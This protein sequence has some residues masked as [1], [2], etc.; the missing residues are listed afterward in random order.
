MDPSSA[1]E[2]FLEAIAA[3]LSKALTDKETEKVIA[4]FNNFQQRLQRLSSQN[5]LRMN[6]EI[7]AREKRVSNC[8]HEGKTCTQNVT[9]GFFKTWVIGYIVKYLIGVLPA[10]LTGKILKNPGILKRSGGNDTVRFA[11]FLS[12]FLSAYKGVLCMMRHFRP[13]HKGDRLNAFVAGSVA[14][15]TLLLDKNKSRRTALTLY[16]FT[17]SI[18]FGSSYL[19]KKWAEHRDANRAADRQA[20]MNSSNRGHK[21]K[22]VSERRWDDI[23]AKIMTS[24]AATVVMSLTAA[25]NLYS[26]FLEPSAVRK[27][28]WNFIMEHSGLPQKFGPMF[29]PMVDTFRSQFN[30]LKEMPRGLEHISIPAGVPSRDFVAQ[31][32]S[33]NIATLIPSHLHHEFQL[34][35]LLHPL[36]PC[37][38]HAID[39][40]TGEFARAVKMY[41]TLNFIVTL[42]FQRKKL[43]TEPKEVAYRYIRSTLR[44]CMFLTVYVLAAFYVPCWMRAILRKET[45]FTYLFNGIVSGL[46][47]LIEAPG[48]QMELALYCLP[49]A[50]ETTWNLLLSRGLVRNI[51]HGDIA[52]F[53]A[54]MGVMMTI[55]QNDPSVINKHYLT[56]LTRIF[57]RN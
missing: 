10:I 50:L 52:L 5:L 18:Q 44:S 11:F 1:W 27:S 33:P 57:G 4:G 16:L 37:S 30:V 49:R 29:P 2:N 26:C 19:M 13:D 14:G 51:P 41:G 8:K 31:N 32:I 20:L 9:R 22:F 35:A 46:A 25:V 56:V 42:V 17:R 45:R 43:V 28:Y 23:L 47:V 15:L 53:S 3:L 54:S 7:T 34:C 12:S 55:Y 40:L 24:S 21:G 48:R 36:T 38:G 39:V 6:L